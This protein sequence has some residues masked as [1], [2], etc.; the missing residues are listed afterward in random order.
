MG[1]CQSQVVDRQVASGKCH[2]G[3]SSDIHGKSNNVRPAGTETPGNKLGGKG[4]SKIPAYELALMT[5]PSE[6]TNVTQA[7]TP[8]SLSAPTSDWKFNL[9]D[10]DFDDI[11]ELDVPFDE[12]E[13]GDDDNEVPSDEEGY[14]GNDDDEEWRLSCARSLSSVPDDL[15]EAPTMNW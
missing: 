10:G 13:E 15:N 5:S 1:A 7:M 8:T 2:G 11:S 3:P 14:E 9:E 4:V 6:R 12:G